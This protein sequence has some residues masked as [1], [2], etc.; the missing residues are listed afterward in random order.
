MPLRAARRE[1][2][3]PVGVH[4]SSLLFLESGIWQHGQVRVRPLQ[5]PRYALLELCAVAPE[6]LGK[7]L[8]R[9][10]VGEVLSRSQE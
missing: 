6:H 10:E 8:L 5:L 1:A 7:L 9:G 4:V 2:T 3:D